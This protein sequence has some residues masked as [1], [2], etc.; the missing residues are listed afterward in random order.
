MKKFLTLLFV[1]ISLIFVSC[2]DKV[3][4]TS[5]KTSPE[6]VSVPGNNRPIA[7]VLDENGHIDFSRIKDGSFDP[8][9]YSMNL[10]ADGKPQFEV[11]GKAPG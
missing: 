1:G 10:D 7:S 3:V 2:G 11:R 5:V 9:G 8:S 4:Q 6:T